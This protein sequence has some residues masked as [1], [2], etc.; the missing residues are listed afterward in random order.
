MGVLKVMG[1]YFIPMNLNT[2]MNNDISIL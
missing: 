2:H 1:S